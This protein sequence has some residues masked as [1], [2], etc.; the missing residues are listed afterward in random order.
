M[1]CLAVLDGAS[2]SITKSCAWTWILIFLKIYQEWIKASMQGYRFQDFSMTRQ[3]NLWTDS[4]RLVK[5]LLRGCL[6]AQLFSTIGQ[7]MVMYKVWRGGSGTKLN[8]SCESGQLS[9][10]LFLHV[11]VDVPGSLAEIRLPRRWCH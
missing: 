7:T 4:K 3:V 11:N 5:V 6:V 1:K 10:E 2:V 9:D 8:V